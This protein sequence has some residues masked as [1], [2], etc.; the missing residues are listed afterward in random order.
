MLQYSAVDFFS[1]IIITGHLEQ[2]NVVNVYVISDHET[3]RQSASIK[4][5]KWGSITPLGSQSINVVVVS[6]CVKYN[7]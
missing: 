4:Y 1:P 6:R 3:V 2:D 5:Y 7:R